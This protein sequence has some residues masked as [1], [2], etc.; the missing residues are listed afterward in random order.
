V[1]SPADYQMIVEKPGFA[2]V[3]RDVT[4]APGETLD[5]I[6]IVLSP[7]DGQVEGKVVSSDGTALGGISIVA[8]DGSYTVETVSY[9]EGDVG[10]FVLRNLAAPGR[11]TVTASAPGYVSESQ[12]VVLE[13]SQTTGTPL[14]MRLVPATGR[15]EGF[16]FLEN[17]ATGDVVVSISGGDVEQTTRPISSSGV[18][19]GQYIF[20]GLPAPAT[21]TLAF[22]GAG[23]L[24][25][26][27]VVVVDSSVNQGTTV[28][29][30]VDLRVSN[31]RLSGTVF[32]LTTPLS[33]AEVT[34]TN[35][36]TVLRTVS[37]DE[38]SSAGAAGGGRGSFAFSNVAPGAYT[39]AATR[40]G[41][42]D[43]VVLVTIEAGVAPAFVSLRLAPQ[44]SIIGR[45]ANG[46]ECALV[47]RLFLFENFGTKWEQEVP[48][49]PIP[50]DPETPAD[51]SKLGGYEFSAVDAPQ[52]FLIAITTRNSDVALGTT[53]ESSVPST[54]VS[55]PSIDL[56]ATQCAPSG[57]R[58]P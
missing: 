27:R 2:T 32:E 1:P 26:V 47:A 12:S 17:A 41:S 29:P 45:V 51:E 54:V 57:G 20:Q 58:T 38:L 44:A 55:A 30:T 8:T 3:I 40:V 14:S 18:P 13:P 39:L 9:T 21:Y 19:A 23:A 31:R 24:P 49:V 53:S 6:G 33:G 22:S 15:I 48:V 10:G 34:L 4:L 37:A 35:G 7:A 11:F 50:D 46:Q 25:Q 36:T 5:N 28:V 43:T 16:V 42:T 52:E 56:G